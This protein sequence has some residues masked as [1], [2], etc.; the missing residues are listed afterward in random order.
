MKRLM[1]LAAVLGAA[2]GLFA[3][4]RPDG[5][6]VFGGSYSVVPGSHVVKDEWTKRFG[7]AVDSYGVGG[8]GFCPKFMANGEETSIPAQVRRMVKGG[9]RYALYVLWCSTNDLN[10]P[11]DGQ[12]AG[13][14]DCVKMIRAHQPDAKIVLFSSMPVIPSAQYYLNLAGLFVGQ[15]ETAKELGLPFL[16]LYTTCGMTPEN[17]GDCYTYDNLH[18]NDT[19]YARIRGVTTDFLA[20]VLPGRE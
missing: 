13:I 11:V 10:R 16:D 15:R 6:A 8:N 17:C 3:A 18:M 14:R 4:E 7:L 5:I 1:V 12:N 20:T 9:K 19:G 2:A